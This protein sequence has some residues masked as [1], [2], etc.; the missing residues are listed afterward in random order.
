MR[1]ACIVAAALAFA[2]A[3]PA[4]AKFPQHV[5]AT[6]QPGGT[7]SE[8]S[9]TVP[10]T[11]ESA[12]IA[13]TPE[14]EDRNPFLTGVRSM[15]AIVPS[16]RKRVL[17]CVGLYASFEHISSN[18]VDFIKESEELELLFLA[19]CL[20]LAFQNESTNARASA[21]SCPAVPI[22]APMNVSRTSGRYR[23]TVRGTAKKPTR[24]AVRVRCRRDAGTTRIKLRPRKRTRSLRSVVGRKLAIGF[25]NTSDKPVSMRTTF[26]V[27]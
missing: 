17:L 12:T 23:I 15:L 27:K 19:A 20:E 9:S 14:A 3:S 24:R 4:A 1:V 2:L 8:T 13:V 16:K 11:A 10:K 6:V 21:T 26:N 18:D 5:D 22:S 7:V 25:Y